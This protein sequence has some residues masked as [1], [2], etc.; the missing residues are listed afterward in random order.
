M[1]LSTEMNQMV[2]RGYFF[3]LFTLITSLL[4]AQNDYRTPLDIPLYLSGNFGELRRSHFHSGLDIKTG[5]ITGEPIYAIADGFVSRIKVSAYG[6]GKALYLDHP[7]GQSSVYAHLS[8]YNEEITA[9]LRDAQY[10]LEQFSVDLHPGQQ[11]LRV[12]KGDVIGWSGNS[13]SSGGPHLHFEIRDTETERPL[14]PLNLG[15]EVVDNTAPIFKSIRIYP[16]DEKS[17][18]DGY[19]SSQDYSRKVY[20]GSSSLRRNGAIPV[21]GKVGIAFNAHD[22]LS[23]TSNYC[24]IYSASLVVD[25][26]EVFAFSFDSLDFSQR[27]LIHAHRDFANYETERVSFQRLFALP[28][29]PLIIYN[30]RLSGGIIYGS[31]GESKELEIILKDK[32]GNISKTSFT[33]QFHEGKP[34]RRQ[35]MLSR[36]TGDY[37]KQMFYFEKDNSFED[38]GLRVDL[39]AWHLFE[40]VLFIYEREEDEE[41]FSDRF[42]LGDASIPLY[43]EMKIQIKP[44]NFEEISPE[45][46]LIAREYKSRNYPLATS[47]DGDYLICNSRNFGTFL[48]LCDTVPPMIRAYDFRRSMKGREEFSFKIADDLSGIEAVNAFIDDRWVLTDFDAK[49]AKV[50]CTYDAARMS[51][52]EHHFRITVTDGR[53]NASEYESKFIW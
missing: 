15:F 46:L 31:D 9:F 3:T 28:N 1:D 35:A 42:V 34:E 11:Q 32:V 2:Q 39:P 29:N 22:Q 16:L 26:D 18:V 38:R 40:D 20:S 50:T 44:K 36:N 45:K 10:E 24:G 12:K 43:D 27:R 33:L 52:G 4:I 51:R 23:G 7:N 14:N 48:V 47:W 19:Y 8:A 30:E 37:E 49:K 5:G 21:G 13:G 17:W 53:G 25:G 41:A 6:Y